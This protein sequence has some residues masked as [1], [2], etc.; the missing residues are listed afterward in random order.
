MV[1]DGFVGFEPVYV[2]PSITTKL[3]TPSIVRFQA[4]DEAAGNA[5]TEHTKVTI[6]PFVTL[7][8]D[9][10]SD[11]CIPVA[12]INLIFYYY[13]G[14]FSHQMLLDYKKQSKLQTLCREKLQIC[15]TTIIVKCYISKIKSINLINMYNT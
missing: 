6:P 10:F 4:T 14:L 7:Y 2:L 12:I 8:V 5:D 1:S 3:S 15:I 13:N 11:T 9:W